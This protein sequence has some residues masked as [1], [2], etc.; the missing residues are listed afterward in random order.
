MQLKTRIFARTHSYR[1]KKETCLWLLLFFVIFVCVVITVVV[2]VV[3][4]ST[5]IVDW[6]GGD[7]AQKSLKAWDLNLF[8]SEL[9]SML[10]S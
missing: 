9:L 10:I 1:E 7:K 8:V 3:A 4:M 2:A 5:I 6:Y